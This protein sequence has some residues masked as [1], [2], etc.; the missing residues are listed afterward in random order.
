MYLVSGT[1]RMNDAL[2]G[3]EIACFTTEL[4]SELPKKI[5]NKEE[6]ENEVINL[7]Y[8]LKLVTYFL[9]FQVCPVDMTCF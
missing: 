5:C 2:M 1:T 8:L 6:N 3:G 7:Q 4:L 9:S